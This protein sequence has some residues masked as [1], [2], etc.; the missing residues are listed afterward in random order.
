M[1]RILTGFAALVMLF[2]C[3]CAA[4][5]AAG[6]NALIE[7]RDSAGLR[8]VVNHP[9]ARFR[10]ANDID[11]KGEDWTPIPFSGELDG[12][13]FG[14]YNL[15]VTQV[16]DEVRTTTDAN[17]KEYENVFAGL[18]SVV[19]DSD[20]HDLKVIG[21]HVEIEG[22]THTFAAILAG[23][24]KYST[25]DNVT[26]DGRVRLDNEAVMAG[27]GGVAGFGSGIFTN[28]N[29]R[30]ELIFN[31]LNRESRCEEFLGSILADGYS[32]VQYCTAEIDGYVSCFGY[33][34]NGGLMGMY[35]TSGTKF[36]L[37]MENRIVNH[38]TISGRIYF[39]EH[40]PDRRAYCKAAVGEI[41]TGLTKSK[42]ND[43]KGWSKKET[44]DYSKTLLP[45]TCENPVYEEKVVPP[46]DGEWGWTEHTC[47]TCGY[48]WRD[49]YT[50][51]Q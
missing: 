25:F 41:R 8:D 29:A 23:F 20:I 17:W 35:Y 12:A 13:G 37:G 5:P 50:A 51:D 27:V 7:I 49:N 1:R 4:V 18:F 24:S 34:H 31:D 32:L 9:G 16:G 38:N 43:A 22:K 48:T 30:V 6:E 26:V 36:A 46:A 2:V 45:E 42:P 19:E 3:A 14:I 15:S 33:C 10:L 44:K 28:C 21:A 39:F 47:S 11:L 40:N